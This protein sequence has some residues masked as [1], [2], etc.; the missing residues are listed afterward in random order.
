M[1]F[2]VSASEPGVAFDYEAVFAR[3][4]AALYEAKRRGRDAVVAEAGGAAVAA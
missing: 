1:S 4:D 3:A 2:G